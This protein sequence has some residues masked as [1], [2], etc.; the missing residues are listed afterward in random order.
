VELPSGSMA[1]LPYATV[2]A[3]PDPRGALLA[4]LQSAYDAGSRLAGWDREA[5][6]SSWC[7]A[8]ERLDA[9]GGP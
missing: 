4:F 5:M 3:A 9:L 7:P 8:P 6:V 2:R 1:L